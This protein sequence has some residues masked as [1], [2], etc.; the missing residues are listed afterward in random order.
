MIWGTDQGGGGGTNTP[1]PVH[2]VGRGADFFPPEAGRLLKA[3]EKIVSNSI[4]LHS[5]GRDRCG[6][7]VRI[8]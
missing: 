3:G 5:N 2:E 8:Q 6:R 7:A 1:W 4:H